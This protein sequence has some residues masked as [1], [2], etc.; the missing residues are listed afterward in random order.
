MTA[1]PLMNEFTKLAHL[2]REDLED[3]L[4]DL[5]YFQGTF[6]S[7]YQVKELYQAQAELVFDEAKSL[8]SHWKDFE[9]EQRE[10]YQWFNPQFILFPLWYATTAQDDASVKALAS[11]FCPSPSG[12]DASDVNEFIREVRE[13]RKVYHKRLMW[14][15]RWASGQVS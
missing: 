1:T 10:A 12:N 8:E 11:S 15:D 5:A 6:Y 14:G 4:N 3:L 13:L 7:M 2:A 9:R